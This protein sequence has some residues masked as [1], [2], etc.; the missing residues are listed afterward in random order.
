[1]VGYTGLSGHITDRGADNRHKFGGL[2]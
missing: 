2:V 1:L